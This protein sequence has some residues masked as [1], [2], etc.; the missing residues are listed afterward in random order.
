MKHKSYS[1]SC[2][3]E[4]CLRSTPPCSS[5]YVVVVWLL[6]NRWE[7][8]WHYESYADDPTIRVRC[9]EHSQSRA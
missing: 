3:F 8:A 2:S 1:L 5:A 9:P 7:A 4:G 6:G